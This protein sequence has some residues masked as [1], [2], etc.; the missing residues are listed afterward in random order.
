VATTQRQAQ[1]EQER[2]A[3]AMAAALTTAELLALTATL[4]AEVTALQATRAAPTVVFA[5][6]P[7]TLG[8]K[9]LIDYS[10]KRGSEIYKQR[11]HAA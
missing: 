8:A 9:D 3:A 5:N 7:Q 1:A 2:N 4:Q 6:T 10:T 11:N